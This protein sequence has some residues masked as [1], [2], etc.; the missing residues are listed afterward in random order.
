MRVKVRDSKF[1]G[2][3]PASPT[4]TEGC[5]SNGPPPQLPANT[6][7]EIYP[8][9]ATFPTILQQGQIK[10]PREAL[11]LQGS[12]SPSTS[13]SH[14]EIF[15]DEGRGRPEWSLFYLKHVNICKDRL[16]TVYHRLNIPVSKNLVFNIFF[17]LPRHKWGFT[18]KI[19]LV[20]NNQK[21]IYFCPSTLWG[22]MCLTTWVCRQWLKGNT[23]NENNL[24][25]HFLHYFFKK[26]ILPT[27]CLWRRFY[28]CCI[29]TYLQ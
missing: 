28:S 14:T 22:N 6:H 3:P 19:K 9:V 8:S 11:K 21:A 26:N 4:Q 27:P 24:F 20:L 12:L 17:L 29:I 5:T 18:R 15:W 2:G 10:I 13:S 23:Q 16:K 1:L 25:F 7:F